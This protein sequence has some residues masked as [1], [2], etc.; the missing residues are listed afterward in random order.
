MTLATSVL[1][2]AGESLGNFLPQLLGAI[3][4]LLI[5]LLLARLLGRVVR[6]ALHAA[7]VDDLG[8]RWRV[9]DTLARAGL[10]TS[11]SAVVGTGVRIIVSVIVIFASLTLL[12][13]EPL[14]QSLNEAV[15]FLPNLLVALAL[16]LAGVILAGLVREWVDR[17]TYQMDFPVP[18]GQLAQA[19]TLALFAITAAAQ[20]GVDADIL[21]LVLGI[22]LA[23]VAATFA[24]AFG[25]GGREVARALNAGRFV[26]ASFDVGETIS[27]G[28][29]R[30]QIVGIETDATVIRTAD[31][32]V[33]VPNHMLVESVVTIH[34]E[35]PRSD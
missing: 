30:G 5:G 23:A 17:V 32:R 14:S 1:E 28:D 34:G 25:L 11:L 31:G 22:V 33:R 26:R 35:T 16:I 10:K 15:L 29:L 12:G 3:V 2:R 4:L 7:G 20:I 27:V 8:A 24:I 21:T 19:A 18:L 6:R 13:L 9:E